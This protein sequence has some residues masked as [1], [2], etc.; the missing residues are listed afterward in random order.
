MR[1][2]LGFWNTRGEPVGRGG[3]VTDEMVAAACVALHS[4]PLV[5]DSLHVP[6]EAVR[7]ALVAALG[8]AP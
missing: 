1:C 8:V 2:Q 5:D 6:S 7:D 4:S 3:V